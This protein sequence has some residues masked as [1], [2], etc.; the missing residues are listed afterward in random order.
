MKLVVDVVDFDESIKAAVL[1]ACG[2]TLVCDNVDEAKQLCY[3]G[4]GGGG[5]RRR[6]DNQYKVV[7]LDGTLIHKSGNITGGAG[8]FAQKAQKWNEKTALALKAKRDKYIAEMTRLENQVGATT[9]FC[10]SIITCIC[11]LCYPM[12]TLVFPFPSFL[13]YLTNQGVLEAEAATAKQEIGSLNNRLQYSEIELK[14]TAE[15]IAA[16][17]GEIATVTKTLKAKTPV[18]TKL[19]AT[20]AVGGAS[21]FVTAIYVLCTLR[22]H[23]LRSMCNFTLYSRTSASWKP[24][25]RR[26]TRPRTR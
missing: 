7:C 8:S 11:R 14:V 16:A 23:I 10:A 21:A 24:L 22:A 5:G 25:R 20:V 3:N 13:L 6:G 15:K 2:N 26:L 1:Y 12:L 17:R 4:G 9:L 18:M 19:A